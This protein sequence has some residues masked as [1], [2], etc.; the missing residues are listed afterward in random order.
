MCRLRMLRQ[1]RMTLPEGEH[2]RSQL[3]DPF[4]HHS[5]GGRLDRYRV[6]GLPWIVARVD[7]VDAAG[8]DLVRRIDGDHR[9]RGLGV[10]ADADHALVLERLRPLSER[11]AEASARLQDQR[12]RVRRHDARPRRAGHHHAWLLS[13]QQHRQQR[14]LDSAMQP[15][16][17]THQRAWIQSERPATATWSVRREAAPALLRSHSRAAGP[18]RSLVDELFLFRHGAPFRA[19]EQQA[20]SRPVFLANCGNLEAKRLKSSPLA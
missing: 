12:A 17:D 13:G 14:L 4:Q 16:E 19:S 11:R 1:V 15:P 9:G 20:Y 6:A 7:P 8:G 5:E 10:E 2:Q 3:D 18:I